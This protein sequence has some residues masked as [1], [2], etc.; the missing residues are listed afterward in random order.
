MPCPLL[1]FVAD[2][3]AVKATAAKLTALAIANQ[4]NSVR[5]TTDQRMHGT[6]GAELELAA[7]SE[8][9]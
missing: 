9:Q 6:H 8:E 2:L 1:V 4:P 7:L 5:A 3:T